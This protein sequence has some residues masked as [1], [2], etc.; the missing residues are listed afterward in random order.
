MKSK[1]ENLFETIEYRYEPVHLKLDLTDFLQN[2]SPVLSNIQIKF[3]QPAIPSNPNSGFNFTNINKTTALSDDVIYI[4]DRPPISKPTEIKFS[5]KVDYK[6]NRFLYNNIADFIEPESNTYTFTY[7]DG[8]I[9]PHVNE[10]P[11]INSLIN[12]NDNTSKFNHIN[13]TYTPGEPNKIKLQFIDMPPLAP[14]TLVPKEYS[15]EEVKAYEDLLDK[16]KDSIK[17]EYGILKDEY[18]NLKDGYGNLKDYISIEEYGDS[19]NEDFGITAPT[20]NSTNNQPNQNNDDKEITSNNLQ[21]GYVYKVVDDT[22]KDTKDPNYNIGKSGIYI[23]SKHSVY[24]FG[25]IILNK[26]LKAGVLTRFYMRDPDNTARYKRLPE[27]DA[28]YK[29]RLE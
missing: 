28:A 2:L 9:T 1:I 16:H 17:D 15:N 13:I 20:L 29:F 8:V 5:I 10:Q 26:Q 14:N 24:E 18:G 6:N 3:D 12:N 11:D 25:K 22:I 23:K 7:K 4:I 27:Q 19:I 21:K